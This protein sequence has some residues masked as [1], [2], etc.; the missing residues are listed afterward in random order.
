MDRIRVGVAFA[1]LIALF[2]LFAPGSPIAA[3]PACADDGDSFFEDEVTFSAKQINRAIDKGIAWLRAKQRPDGSWG[4]I[5]GRG[6]YGG[7]K[8]KGYGHPA[9]PTA[10]A[11]YALLR[12]GVPADDPQI[13]KGFE[14]I[15]KS[16]WRRPGG[17]Y[18][19]SALLLAVC[20]T[21]EV[22]KPSNA[23][24]DKRRKAPKPKPP[25]LK[26]S[27]RAWA[28][29]LVHHLVSKKSDRGWRYQLS[30]K[31]TSAYG[32]ESDLSSTQLA[33]LAL[34]SAHR[35]GIKVKKQVWEDILRYA[36]D[37]QE[38]SGPEWTYVYPRT[39]TSRRMRARGFAYIKGGAA[40]HGSASGSMTACGLATVVMARSVLSGGDSTSKSWV[41][42]QDATKV[43]HAVYDGL[44]WLA[45]NW[46]S[47]E[48]PPGRPFSYH[49]YYLCSLKRAMVLLRSD[50][51]GKH[52]WYSEMGQE[53]LNRQHK[54]GHW[55]TRSTH[56]P[57]DTLDTCFALLFLDR[58]RPDI[59]FGR[60][61]G[62]DGPQK[63]RPAR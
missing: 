55:D 34:F 38:Q 8:G 47:F 53:L 24:K 10:L 36:L 43:K 54:D 6:I 46:S 14:Y 48:N 57:H 49:I 21:A 30:T 60:V 16:G 20:A 7:A 40:R 56:G 33:A 19:T 18:E 37:Q 39:R 31:E 28:Q 5:E 59:P 23:K 22:P 29:Q 11:L 44:A 2:L 17:S 1:A 61:R 45:R 50:L 15:K 42:R 4:V 32:G 9:G 51:V 58:K 25:R 12:A 41:A 35:L 26:R 13:C 52:A 63:A 27:F 62:D 3:P